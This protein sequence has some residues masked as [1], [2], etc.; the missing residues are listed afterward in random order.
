LGKEILN[1]NVSYESEFGRI[2][3]RRKVM[4]KNKVGKFEG[5]SPLGGSRHRR[6]GNILNDLNMYRSK[7]ELRAYIAKPTL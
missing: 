1:R 6:Q 4:P 2:L 7:I 3:K 5:K